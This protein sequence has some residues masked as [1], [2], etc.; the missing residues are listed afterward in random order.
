MN[1]IRNALG[2][3]LRLRRIDRVKSGA[4]GA[5][6]LR[7]ARFDKRLLRFE[8]VA[9]RRDLK[10]C[11]LLLMNSII[12]KE[13]EKTTNLFFRGDERRRERVGERRKRLAQL[14]EIALMREFFRIARLGVAGHKCCQ[15]S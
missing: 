3:E 6:T 15:F 14:I 1:V 7:N 11:F 8:F 9:R 5:V 13:E 2:V 10:V 4:I 12:S